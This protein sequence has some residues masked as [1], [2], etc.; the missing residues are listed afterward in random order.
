MKFL[1]NIYIVN[2]L[3][4]S[5]SLINTLIL[6]HSSDIISINLKIQRVLK[7]WYYVSSFGGKFHVIIY[8]MVTWHVSTCTVHHIVYNVLYL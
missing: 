8:Y 7:Y 3:R 2:M 5:G 6:C 1:R 4:P